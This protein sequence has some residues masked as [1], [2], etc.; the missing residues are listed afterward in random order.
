M[1]ALHDLQRRFVDAVLLDRAAPVEVASHAGRLAVHRRHVV[2]SLTKCLRSTFP[3]VERLVGEG[4][5]AFACARFIAASPP[6]KPCLAEYGDAFAGF[7]AEFEP[8]AE[9]AYLPDVARLEWLMHEASLAPSE[10]AMDAASF[11][12]LDPGAVADLKWRLDPSIRYLAARWPVARIHAANT[13]DHGEAVDL[14]LGPC[15]IEIRRRG[16]KVVAREIERSALAFRAALNTG[17]SLRQAIN[18][19]I[20]ADSDFSPAA[21]LAGLIDEGVACDVT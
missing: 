3:V 11:S 16:E 2:A 1:A 4:F 5:F 12:R 10:T 6:N 19:A 8:C 21:A 9:H 7:L 13:G 20:A 14:S 17:S 15:W 18:A